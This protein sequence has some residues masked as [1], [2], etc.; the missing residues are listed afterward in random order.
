MSSPLRSSIDRFIAAAA[1]VLLAA[2][3][4]R[5]EVV[6]RDRLPQVGATPL[7]VVANHVNGLVDPM[8]LLGTLRLP[9]R[10]LGKSTLWRIPILRQILQLAAVIPVHRRQDE[11]QGASVGAARNEEAFERA[12]EVLRDRGVLAL[13]P[14]G[15][16]HDH[17]RLQPLRTGAARIVRGAERAFGP[18]GTRIVPVGLFFEE[19][20]R[21]RSRALVVVGEPLDPTAAELSPATDGQPEGAARELTA[22][23]ADA[24]EAVTFNADSWV[25]SRWIERGADIVANESGELPQRRRLAVEFLARQAV[26][27]GYEALSER[28]PQAVANAVEAVKDYDRLLELTRLEDEQVLASYPT[29]SMIRFLFLRWLRAAFEFPVALLGIVLNALPYFLVGQVSRRFRDEP[30]QLATYKI[31]P[32]ILV[33]PGA[34]ALEAAVAARVLRTPWAWLLVAV[35]PIA[36]WVAARFLQRLE[37]AWREGRA[38]YLVRTRGRVLEELRE[39]RAKVVARLRDLESSLQASTAPGTSR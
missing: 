34:W 39:R 11:A 27:R 9:A 3:F 30:N 26:A 12:H 6:G 14:E 1:R 37:F 20:G 32:G 4:R 10:L 24:L 29:R 36:G 23:I 22:R 21:F 35:A 19:R 13:F 33:Y 15:I 7:V 17:P 38:W 8:F 28:E 5:V 18:L 31:F 25:E 16:S 2:F